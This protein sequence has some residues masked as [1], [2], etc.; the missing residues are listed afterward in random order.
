MS[1]DALHRRIAADLQRRITGGEWRPGDQLPSRAELGAGYGVHEQTVRL[2]V[3]LLRKRGFLEG[4]ARRRLYVAY[5]PAVR[6]LTDPDVDWPYGVDIISVD[7]CRATAD[8]AARLAVPEGVLLHQEVLECWDP[9]GRS[10]MLVT[11]WWRG[12]RR[13]HAAAAVE[14]GVVALSEGQAHSLGL[15]VDTV[16]YRL[17]R[18]R[19][20]SA[21][22]PVETADLVLPMDRW[23]VRLSP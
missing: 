17:L 2:A 7:R 16:A 4:E 9:G 10:A 22:R 18:T 11:S 1:A 3:R 15:T 13:R 20:D 6:T 5:S 8:L 19:L 12:R 21:G 14:L 23:L